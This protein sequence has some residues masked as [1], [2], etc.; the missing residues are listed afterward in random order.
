MSKRISMLCGLLLVV[1]MAFSAIGCGGAPAT[2]P[3][4]S[5]QTS[6]DATAT[7]STSAAEPV[8]LKFWDMAWGPAEAFPVE[9]EKIIAK[10]TSEVAPHVT[11]EYTNLPW[12]NWYEQF[13]TAV[14]SNGAP[15][16][17]TGGGYMPFQFSTNDEMADLQWIVDEWKKE[18]TDKDFYEGMLDYWRFHD[19]QVGIPFNYDPRATFIRI[20]WLEEKGLEMP[21]TYD[22]FI[23]VAKALTDKDQGIYG[24]AF[25]VTTG[26]AGPFM[27][28]ATGN[29][30][31]C[32]NKDG[33]ANVDNE[34]NLQVMKLFN[35]LQKDGSLPE[36]IVNYSGDDADKL[37]MAGKAGISIRS[38]G[39]FNTYL[40]GGMTIDQ[41][42]VMPPLTS[43][44]G[45]KNG[46]VNPNAYMMFE[47]SQ[48]KE[49]GMKFLKWYSE[50][51]YTIWTD[52]KQ[53][54]FPARI[55]Y[56][57]GDEFKKPQRAQIID[58]VLSN[59]V[60]LVYPL[61]SGVPSA[62]SVEGQKFDQT[63]MQAALTMDEDGWKD[64]LATLQTQLE[65]LIADLDK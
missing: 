3:T 10:Y 49:E 18:G 8:T 59:A 65:G 25:G 56:L 53:D 11:I 26:S 7:E 1:A 51:T 13:S 2:E 55:S 64:T 48:N 17:C 44:S 43:P 40:N 62:S 16:V 41:V 61:Q 5:A 14:A 35:T 60:Q 12:S 6:G 36:G 45:T 57:E 47:Q 20:D 54:G 50:N 15:D 24:V 28:F 19:K 4:D 38:A 29:G 21:E 46:Q 27:Q 34:R 42:A 58:R 23:A 52:G 9:S 63:C 37:F 32:Y 33:T 31:M 30:G 22:D 39:G